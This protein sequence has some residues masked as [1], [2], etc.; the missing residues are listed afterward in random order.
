MVR[1][2]NSP[3][4]IASEVFVDFNI[5]FPFL[6]SKLHTPKLC[7]CFMHIYGN[8]RGAKNA[9]YSSLSPNSFHYSE[10]SKHQFHYTYRYKPKQKIVRASHREQSFSRHEAR[11]HKLP[12]TIHAKTGFTLL[13][14]SHEHS[15]KNCG[16]APSDL[17]GNI[18]RA[19][20]I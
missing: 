6:Y 11:Q 2:N 19:I 4:A 9:A 1:L 20:S 13:N 10:V 15:A 5:E 3:R 16:A 7:T 18:A 12:H 17:V 8:R 14:V